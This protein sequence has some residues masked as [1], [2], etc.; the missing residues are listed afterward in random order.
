M[1]EWNYSDAYTVRFLAYSNKLNK[2]KEDSNISE[3]NISV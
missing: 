1:D 2:Y 3:F